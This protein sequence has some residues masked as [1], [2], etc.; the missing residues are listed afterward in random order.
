MKKKLSRQ[1]LKTEVMRY[2]AAVISSIIFAININTFINAGNLFPG[3]FTGITLLLQKVFLQYLGISLPYSLI[4]Y[5]LNAFPI[6][7]GFRKIGFKFTA[8]SCIVVVLTGLLTDILPVF[9]VTYDVLLISIFGA[10]INGLAVA[11]SLN[12]GAGSGGTD[13]IAIYVGEKYDIDP[14]N[15]VLIFNAII[16][17]IAGALFGWDA[18]LYSIIFQFISTQVVNTMHKKFKKMTMLVITNKPQEVYNSIN[19]KTHHSATKF[20]GTGCYQGENKSLVYSVVT[21]N[22]VRKMVD[23]IHETDPEAFVNVLKT[24]YIEGN[25]F[26][27]KDY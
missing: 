14:W 1:E 9:T 20:E 16:L 13:F 18:A 5:L 11:I 23:E 27:S 19:K 2:S 10:L 24:E 15:Y 22:E 25:F 17:I 7:L 12:A 3:G 21:S 6:M 26:S 8:S 4:N